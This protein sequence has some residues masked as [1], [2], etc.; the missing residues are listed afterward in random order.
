MNGVRYGVGDGKLMGQIIKGLYS[1]RGFLNKNDI[2]VLEFLANKGDHETQKAVLVGKKEQ[3]D[4]NKLFEDLKNIQIKYLEPE[5]AKYEDL[6][7]G[8]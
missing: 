7:T 4:L 1:N 6:G 5:L 3:T 8:N 2:K